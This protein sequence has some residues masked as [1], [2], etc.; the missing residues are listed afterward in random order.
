MARI[1]LHA[2]QWSFFSSPATIDRLLWLALTIS[3]GIGAWARLHDLGASSL[4]VDEYY[5]LQSVQ[6]IL[7]VGVPEYAC[8]GYYVRGLLH[9][10]LSAGLIQWVHVT[11]EVAI[12]IPSVIASAFAVVGAWLVAK[13]AS[14][15]RAAIIVS[16]LLSISLWQI[17]FARFGRM[18]ALFQACTVYYAF[19]TLRFVEQG[20]DRDLLWMVILAALAVLSHEGGVLLCAFTLIAVLIRPTAPSA[21]HVVVAVLALAA[22]LA[23]Q[24]A[25]FRYLGVDNPYSPDLLVSATDPDQGQGPIDRPRL[26]P[27]PLQL[28]VALLVAAVLSAVFLCRRS[29]IRNPGMSVHRVVLVACA[30]LAVLGALAL[31]LWLLALLLAVCALAVQIIE[32]SLATKRDLLLPAMAL[33]FAFIVAG[34]LLATV[35]A[36][37]QAD[38]AAA[39][40]ITA[41]L[42]KSYLRYPDLYLKVWVQWRKVLPA[43]G[44]S[45]LAVSL[46]HL[47]S[48][49]GPM[50]VSPISRLRYRWLVAFTLSL[51]IGAALADQPYQA[52]RYTFFL[53]PLFLTLLVSGS[54][55]ICQVLSTRVLAQIAVWAVVLG[56]FV[57]SNEWHVRHLLRISSPEFLYRLDY[58]RSLQEH[59][60]RRWDYRGMGSALNQRRHPATW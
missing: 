52:T 25:D 47:P 28:R 41:Q 48:R 5:L 36:T 24:F 46:V 39:S 17:E 16:I 29:I 13:H 43:L 21:Q 27:M 45:I 3:V 11:P 35:A 33:V 9:Q 18:Y 14:G 54:M 20:K 53:Y 15:R 10:Y 4:A 23:F 7:R 31:Q 19:A 58:E 37:S 2:R 1:R 50:Q 26:L 38:G 56:C 32:P 42:L 51:L 59:F 55:I 34:I 60:Y 12:R 44:A 49:C 22:G 40:H 57:S 8:G 30:W 6:N